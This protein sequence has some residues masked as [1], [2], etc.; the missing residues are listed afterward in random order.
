[1]HTQL[2][3]NSYS[4]T[5]ATE[6][7]GQT[8]VSYASVKPTTNALSHPNNYSVSRED[9]FNQEKYFPIYLAFNLRP[10]VDLSISR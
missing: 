5:L 10:V 2:H 9:I 7:I 8:P 3:R 1:M 4:N 6:T